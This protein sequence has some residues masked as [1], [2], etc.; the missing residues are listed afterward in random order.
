MLAYS[1]MYIVLFGH[2]GHDLTLGDLT[3]AP[4]ILINPFSLWYLTSPYM[5]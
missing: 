5:H 1:T 2:C 3:D 4:L